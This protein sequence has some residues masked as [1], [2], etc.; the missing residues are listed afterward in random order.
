MQLREEFFEI[1]KETAKEGLFWVNGEVFESCFFFFFEMT[2]IEGEYPQKSDMRRISK[3][4]DRHTHTELP[5]DRTTNHKYPLVIYQFS[6]FFF[7]L[8]FPI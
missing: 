2:G 3:E 5:I 1:T 7:L 6:C 4:T 8:L